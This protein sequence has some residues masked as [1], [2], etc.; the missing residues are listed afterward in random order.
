MS[1]TNF[2][3]VTMRISLSNNHQIKDLFLSSMILRYIVGIFSMIFLYLFRHYLPFSFPNFFYV[4]VVFVLANCLLHLAS[5]KKDWIEPTFH[6]LP[7]F[8]CG[9]S[10]LVFLTSGGF[11]SPFVITHFVSAI[12]TGVLYTSNKW[13][14]FHSFLILVI[15]YVGVAFLQK[16]GIIP[17]DVAYVQSML[18]NDAF[19][20]FVVIVTSG[21]FGVGFI[22]VKLL[23]VQIHHTLDDLAHSF[24][25]IVKGTTATVGQDFFV[26]VIKHISES[27]LMRCVM[28]AEFSRKNESIRT[29][30]VWKDGKADENFESPVG[31]TIFAEVLSQSNCYI[32]HDVE[33]LY[34]SNALLAQCKATFFFGALLLDS[35]GKPIGLLCMVN[36]KP[37]KNLYLVEPLMTIFASRAAAELERKI[38]EEK[39][40]MIEM[41]LAHAHKMEAIGNLVGGIAHDFNNMVSAIGGCAQ[42]LKTKLDADSPHQRYVTHIINA[43]THT[44]ELINRLTGFARR[45]KPR[46]VPVDVHKVID[47]TFVL[48]EGTTKKNITLVKN[49]FASESI[50]PSDDASLQNALLNMAINARDAMEIEG[51]TLTFETTTVV[52]DKSNPICQSFQIPT[53]DYMTVSISDNGI[54]M[55]DEVLRHL[56]EPFFTTKPKG[57]GTGFGLANVWGFVENYKC[58][59]T[60]RSKPGE[61]SAFTLFLPLLRKSVSPASTQ[62]VSS[63][64]TPRETDNIK[65]IL[66]VDDEAAQREISREMLDNKGFSLIFKENGLE[67]VNYMKTA[68]LDVDLVILD[69]MM[70]VMNG[71]DAF[72]ELRKID[73]KLKILIASGYIN[74]KDLKGIIKEPMTAFIQKPFSGEM[75]LKAIHELAVEAG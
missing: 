54:G 38:A 28:I 7:Y 57:K 61:G 23:N 65:T 2:I 10:P 4:S 46:I 67:A 16:F 66:V 20:Y 59:I 48:M 26:Q 60:V 21:L 35:K 32:D 69:L 44:V 62:P 12:G 70:P 1:P 22:M 5:L 68:Q 45:E 47:D 34:Q 71:H 52:L 36:D 72:Y 43:G 49:L 30:A 39:Q 3:P 15:S 53:G 41:Q 64:Q 31:G 63:M 18:T 11:L 55:N 42:L 6:L 19:F 58:A 51:G 75:L 50:I 56:F 8:D 14:P 37:R 9:F 33:R 17:C 73:P 74:K 29:L 27:L 25:M 24:D 13:L 40:K